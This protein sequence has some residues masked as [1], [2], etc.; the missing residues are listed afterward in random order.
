MT[1]AVVA[2]KLGHQ[3]GHHHV[4]VCEGGGEGQDT[5]GSVQEE[6]LLW[7][8][9]QVLYGGR[10]QIEKSICIHVNVQDTHT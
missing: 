10:I 6:T 1:V 3:T 9:Q 2:A 8:E 4:Q 7:V 5:G